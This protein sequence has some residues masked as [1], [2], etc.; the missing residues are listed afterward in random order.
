MR[1]RVKKICMQICSLSPDRRRELIPVH[2]PEPTA[3]RLEIAGKYNQIRAFTVGRGWHQ[4][5]IDLR[6]ERDATDRLR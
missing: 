1:P 6:L 5:G 2:D 4:D 3:G